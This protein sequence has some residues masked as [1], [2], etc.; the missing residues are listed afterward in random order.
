MTEK[1]FPDAW[2]DLWAAADS[3]RDVIQVPLPALETFLAC[4]YGARTPEGLVVKAGRLHARVNRLALVQ[5]LQA[6]ANEPCGGEP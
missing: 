4:A 1:C 3:G 2:H 5:S 6:H